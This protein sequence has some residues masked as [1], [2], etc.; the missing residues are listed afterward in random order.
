VAMV[1]GVVVFDG[2]CLAKHHGFMFI[3]LTTKYTVCT[4]DS[5][6]FRQLITIVICKQW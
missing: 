1:D 4:E 2:L 5:F 6:F 3:P